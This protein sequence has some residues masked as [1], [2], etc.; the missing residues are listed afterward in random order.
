MFLKLAAVRSLKASFAFHFDI[1]CFKNVVLKYLV[2][3]RYSPFC[4]LFD[5]IYF[6]N[7]YSIY[8]KW[9]YFSAQLLSKFDCRILKNYRNFYHEIN[10][11]LNYRWRSLKTYYVI[12]LISYSASSFKLLL[13]HWKF[14]LTH[15]GT[16]CLVVVFLKVCNSY[17]M[18]KPNPHFRYHSYLIS[19][20][21]CSH[22]FILSPLI[23]SKIPNSILPLLYGSIHVNCAVYGY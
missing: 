21:T 2:W 18:R 14:R 4:S 10:K 6:F 3:Y 17:S 11:E 23:A 1:E 19:C 12:S 22:L 13:T 15:Y 7:L 5:N 9:Q 20:F 8:M 16:S